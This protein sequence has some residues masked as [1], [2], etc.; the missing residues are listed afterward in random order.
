MA[1]SAGCKNSRHIQATRFAFAAILD[2]NVGDSSQV[3]EQLKN[4]QQIQA[5][6]RAFAAVLESGTVVTWGDPDSGGDSSLQGEARN[7]YVGTHGY[8]EFNFP[9]SGGKAL[10]HR[11]LIQDLLGGPLEAVLGVHHT[12]GERDNNQVQNLDLLDSTQHQGVRRRGR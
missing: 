3:A 4:L 9:R 12:D 11:Q 2:S 7:I 6:G 5:T 1:T 10:Y 8:W